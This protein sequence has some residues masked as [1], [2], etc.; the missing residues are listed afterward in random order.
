MFT[1]LDAEVVNA[2]AEAAP[3]AVASVVAALTEVDPSGF[4]ETPIGDLPELPDPLPPSTVGPP[5]L[6]Q[7]N[8]AVG[9]SGP[10]TGASKGCCKFKNDTLKV[11]DN[12]GYRI[13]NGAIR[14]SVK[15]EYQVEEGQDPKKCCL[16]NWVKGSITKDGALP[17]SH[18]WYGYRNQAP[19]TEGRWM[20]D[21]SLSLDPRYWAPNPIN[22][23]GTKGWATDAPGFPATWKKSVMDFSF[24]LCVYN[25]DELPTAVTLYRVNNHPI[26]L[27]T[28]RA[29]S[30]V[31]WEA[32]A[33]TDAEGKETFG[34]TR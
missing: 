25:C 29:I 20:V 15:F 16:V 26:G 27:I 6:A 8:A 22:Y 3:L 14:R 32:K 34:R 18:M 21:R 4:G 12:P 1:P 11:P 13:A 2:V 23:D 19:T 30:C 17:E 24:Q 10:S 33:F 7:S 5:T 9:A 31:S 28:T